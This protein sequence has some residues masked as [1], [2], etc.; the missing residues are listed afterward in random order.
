MKSK[1]LIWLFSL[2]GIV[3][4]GIL[5]FG[6]NRHK[7]PTKTPLELLTGG[8]TNHQSPFPEITINKPASQFTA[9]ERKLLE[10]IYNERFKPAID[11]WESAYA[12][13]LPFD[14][15]Q[16]TLD[17]FHSANAGLYTF[18]L[19][20]TTFT[21][22]SSRK[23]TKVFYLMTKQAAKDLNSIPADGQPRNLTVPVTREQVLTMAE[24][25]TGLN[26]ELKDI[27][28]KPT[29][30]FCNIDGGADVEVGI[31][32]ENGMELVRVDNLSFVI[33][34]NGTLISYQ[35]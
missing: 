3:A 11:K 24:A 32:Y 25:D 30:T 33:D 13:H 6:I 2:V 8:N 1:K 23:G 14:A 27:V 7:E 28:I 20:D 15:S 21:I 17:K 10:Q 26:Y 22:F 12:G 35:H 18:M 9:E 5:I 16:I 31:K 29:A 34:S 4:V 19:G